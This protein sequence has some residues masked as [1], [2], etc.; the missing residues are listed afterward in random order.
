MYTN[1][2][3]YDISRIYNVLTW[4]T[5]HDA[6]DINTLPRLLYSVTQSE[7]KNSWIHL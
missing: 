1:D 7:K 4:V 2:T 3:T 6:I 5:G